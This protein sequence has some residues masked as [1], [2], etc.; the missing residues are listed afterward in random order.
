[1][2]SVIDVA[3]D[4][5]APQVAPEQTRDLATG[6]EQGSVLYFPNLAFKFSEAERRFF[7]PRWADPKSKNISYDGERDTLAGAVGSDADCGSLRAI[8]KRYRKQSI[9]L[10]NALFPNYKQALRVARTSFRPVRVEGRASSWRKDDS[11]LHID[12]FPSRPNQGERILRVFHNANPDGEA[13]VWRVGQPFEDAAKHFLPEITAPLPGSAWVMQLVRITKSRRSRYDH[14]MLQLHDRMK[15]DN[16]YQ[17]KSPQITMPFAA[18]GSWVC[19]SDQTSHAAMSGQFLFEQTLHL[20][21]EALYEPS[22]SPL[23]IL[24]RLTHAALI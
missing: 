2:R 24:E 14:I 13:R 18:G 17:Q 11:R 10:I 22:R 19:F 3:L 15:A 12:A 4:Q 23:K 9:G 6:L 21:V 20:P 7:D 5:W 1:M 8:L 16:E